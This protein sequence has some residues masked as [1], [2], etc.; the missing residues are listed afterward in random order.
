VSPDEEDGQVD[1]SRRNATVTR[2]PVPDTSSPGPTGGAGQ[3]IAAGTAEWPALALLRELGAG[4]STTPAG[5]SS[6]TS[7][8][9][10]A[11]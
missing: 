9:A 6:T 11:W 10:R 4:S 2:I 3:V 8:R 5:T 1:A 7:A